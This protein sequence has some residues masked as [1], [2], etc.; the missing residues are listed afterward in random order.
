MAGSEIFAEILPKF[1]AKFRQ[2]DARFWLYRHRFLQVNTRFTAFFEIY[3]IIY[4]T[5]L[6]FVKS[7]QI[8]QHLQ[9]CC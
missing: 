9:T 6:K 1:L 5:I 8:L 3:Q 7:L 2:N 4:P